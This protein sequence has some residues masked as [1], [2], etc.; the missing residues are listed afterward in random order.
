MIEYKIWGCKTRI[1]S[2]K[3]IE[4]DYLVLKNNTCCSWHK[5]KNKINLFYL[6]DGIVIIKTEN[7]K[8]R[9]IGQ[10]FYEVKAKTLHQF[11]AKKSSTMIEIAYVEKGTINSDDI[12]RLVQGGKFINNKFFTEDELK[13]KKVRSRYK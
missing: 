3:Q 8:V 9:L 12:I 4:V 6:I 11:I 7:K 2:N 1:F 5:H 13:N 10:D